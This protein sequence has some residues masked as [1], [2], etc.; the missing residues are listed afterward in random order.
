MNI[1]NNDI[2]NDW[3]FASDQV[4][5]GFTDNG[6][7]SRQHLLNPAIFSLVGE[8]RGKKILDAGCGQGYLCRLLAKLGAK[9]TGIEP[10]QKLTEYAIQREAEEKLGIEYIIQDLSSQ[11]PFDSEFDI[12]VSNMVFMDIPEYETAMRNCIKSLKKDGQ[13]VFSIL[14][15]CFEE[16]VDWTIKQSVETKEYF[17]KY[18]VKQFIGHFFHRTLSEYVNLVIQEGCSITKLVEPQLDKS[19][20]LEI[21]KHERNLHVPSFLVV[22]AK[23]M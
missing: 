5:A 22:Q 17:E 3:S 8:V 4:I 21:K 1:S 18:Q 10:A 14:H 13:F 7:F 16:S 9:V 2:I 20:A 6:D 11:I 15:P 23:K 12:V 19:V